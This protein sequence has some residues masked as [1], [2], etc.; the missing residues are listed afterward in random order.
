MA[1]R[2]S[3]GARRVC[4]RPRAIGLS[5][6]AGADHHRFRRRQRQRRHRAHPRRQA[7]AHLGPAGSHHQPAGRRRR[8]LGQGRIA[9]AERRL[10]ALHPRHL[11]IPDLEGNVRRG[12]EPAAGT[13]ARLRR[14]RLHAAAAAVHRRLAQVRH[15]QHRRR[16]QARQG[17]AR[18]GHLRGDRRRPAHPPDHGAVPGPHR[19]QAPA[20]AVFRRHRA[21]V[22]RR[23]ERPGQS[24][25]RRL[26]RARPLD[27]GR[28]DQG[29][30][31]HRAG[32]AAR[33]REPADRCRDRAGFL[34]RRL[35][36]AGGAAR[37]ARSD[38]PQ[39]QRRLCGPR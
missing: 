9:V 31:R 2:C 3:A 1:R 34:C 32:A 20:R 19:H 15:Q 29:P 8:H 22:E 16:H 6:Q 36:G 39:G 7:V 26:C 4:L 24:R 27:Q 37:H 14:D 10:H 21:G 13:A 5:E 30:R 35:G 12:A 17:E 33:L 23:D 18:R 11:A 25:A 38:H 28:P